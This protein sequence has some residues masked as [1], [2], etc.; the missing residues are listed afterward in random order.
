MTPS[1]EEP[2]VSP[3]PSSERDL[4]AYSRAT[5]RR[6]GLGAAI[7]VLGVGTLL[8]ALLQGAPAAVGSLLCFGVAL[9]PIGLIIL[10][11]QFIDW[12]LR[13]TRGS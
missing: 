9:V 4:R 10:A 3:R 6:L 7:V 8:V 2:D 13:R 11:F 5:L 12:A 1:P